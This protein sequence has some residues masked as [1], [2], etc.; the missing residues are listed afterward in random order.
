MVIEIQI[1]LPLGWR[2]VAGRWHERA[3]GM[4]AMSYFL[5]HVMV[6]FN[7]GVFSL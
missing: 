5:I 6:T 2:R 4:L 7:L 3:P 1:M